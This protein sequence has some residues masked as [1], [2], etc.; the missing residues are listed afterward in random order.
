MRMSL[1]I[2][3]HIVAFGS[4]AQ[5]VLDYS[6]PFLVASQ[7]G[8]RPD[9]PKSITLIPGKAANTLPDEINFYIQKLGDRLKR[10][11]QVPTAWNGRIFR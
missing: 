6:K 5:Q 1:I 11:Q 10:N 3:L 4:F 7:L 2:A 8:Y 9:S